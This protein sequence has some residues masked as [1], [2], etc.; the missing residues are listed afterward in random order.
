[1]QI[2]KNKNRS[3]QKY[4]LHSLLLFVIVKYVFY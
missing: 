1:M 3:L 2:W 4:R